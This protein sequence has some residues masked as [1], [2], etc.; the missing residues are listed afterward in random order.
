MIPVSAYEI[1]LCVSP[2]WTDRVNFPLHLVGG[3]PVPVDVSKTIQ[4]KKHMMFVH[5]TITISAN[6]SE[7]IIMNKNHIAFRRPL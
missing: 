6:L 5:L 4:E 1:N 3:F 2:R 7:V